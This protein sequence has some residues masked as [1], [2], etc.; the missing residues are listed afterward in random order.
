M[1]FR[2]HFRPPVEKK[3]S[4][5]EHHGMWPAEIVRRWLDTDLRVM[6]GLEASYE[7]ACRLVRIA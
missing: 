2:D 3:H 6:L 1:P 5:D 7:E 4:W